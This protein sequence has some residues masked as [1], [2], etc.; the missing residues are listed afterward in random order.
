[1]VIT[2]FFPHLQDIGGI[3]MSKNSNLVYLID[4]AYSHQCLD[5][6]SVTGWE[7]SAV[8]AVKQLQS[9]GIDYEIARSFVAEELAIAPQKDYLDVS[10]GLSRMLTGA[11]P[12]SVWQLVKS[13][14]NDI[15]LDEMMSLCEL[16]DK[17]FYKIESGAVEGKDGYRTNPDESAHSIEHRLEHKDKE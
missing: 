12:L 2:L 3:T 5:K 4:R 6:N 15:D 7:S 16:P 1:V 14:G 11:N 13:K 9:Y 17:T 10:A 8:T